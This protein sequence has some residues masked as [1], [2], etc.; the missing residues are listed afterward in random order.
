MP[1]TAPRRGR[2]G[3]AAFCGVL[4]LTW[5]GCVGC[6]V[7]RGGEGGGNTHGRKRTVPLQVVK[8]GDR[9]LAL[10]PITIDGHGPFHFAL[11]TGA[12]SS[13]ID[14]GLARQLGL[15]RTGRKVTISGVAGSAT[16]SI[17]R[18]SHWKVGDVRLSPQ[19][20]AAIDLGSPRNGEQLK[21]LLGSDVLNDFE[22]ITVDYDD[23]TLT[24]H[25]H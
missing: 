21:G 4:L 1:S 7:G 24:L 10:E 12:S 20:L 8:Q 2:A 23:E 16:V 11:D 15:R 3:A 22:S 25:E 13:A 14:R 17:V 6:V 5:T 19:R 9:T 18:V